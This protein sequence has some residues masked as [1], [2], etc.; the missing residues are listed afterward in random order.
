MD[1]EPANEGFTPDTNDYNEWKSPTEFTAVD[2]GFEQPADEGFGDKGDDA[3]RCRKYGYSYT[4]ACK[5]RLNVFCSCGGD[6]HFARDCTEPKKMTG[7]C[8][9]CGETGHNK[10][11]C[12]NP[13][14]A[15]SFTGA[16]FVC[17]KDG[18]PAAQ[19]PDKP[20]EKCRICGQEGY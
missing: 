1:Q 10:A 17:G 8:Y 2:N 11:D 7:E 19:C 5:L 15:R 9:N 6:G 14:V 20:A 12:L 3:N 16:C 13:K 18:H 4:C